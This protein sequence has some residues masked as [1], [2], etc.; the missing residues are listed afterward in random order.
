MGSMPW[1]RLYTEIIDDPKMRRF[2]GDQFRDWI[3]LLCLAREAK[4][5]GVIEMS[6]EDAAWRLRRPVEDFKTSLALFAD[7]D[8]V[9]VE[10]STITV[11]HFLERQ[12]DKPSDTPEATRERKRKSRASHAQVTRSHAVDTDVDVHVDADRDLGTPPPPSPTPDGAGE[13]AGEEDKPDKPDKSTPKTLD[14]ILQKHPRYT[15]EQQ[16]AIRDYW[17]AVRF[18]R[19]TARVSPKIM[20]DEMDYWARFPPDI[21]M[22]ALSI[23]VRKCQ[24]KDERYTRGIMRRIAKER[25]LG[26]ERGRDGFGSRQGHAGHSAASRRPTAS[27]YTSGRYGK[28]FA[29]PEPNAPG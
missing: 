6:V 7:L 27:D 14:E 8:M 21:V 20:A 1:L 24:D 4:E 28:F 5:P 11:L 2:T 9:R 10:D 26:I 3:H 29:G 12:Y 23:H 16:A 17:D 25:R 13:G 19:K 18:T 22:E 15:P